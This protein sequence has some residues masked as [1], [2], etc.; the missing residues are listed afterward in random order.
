MIGTSLHIADDELPD[1]EGLE[2]SGLWC[3]VPFL[4]IELHHIV[5]AGKA[6]YTA[7]I[8]KNDPINMFR[9]RMKEIK[10]SRT[11][12]RSGVAIYY[13]LI[14]I[15]IKASYYFPLDTAGWLAVKARLEDVCE[16]MRPSAR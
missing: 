15:S 5:G 11:P 8:V 10:V 3:G 2:R 9:I 7:N 4:V 12:K 14:K 1:V 16:K 6:C 13:V